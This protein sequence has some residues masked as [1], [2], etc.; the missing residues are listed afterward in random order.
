MTVQNEPS[1]GYN[2]EHAWNSLGFNGTL[3]RDFIKIDLGPELHS[4]GF[5]K[6]KLMIYDGKLGD[7][8]EFTD[9]VLADEEAAKYV[10]GVAFHWYNMP[11]AGR[12]DLDA[13]RKQYPDKFVLATEACEEWKGKDQHVWLGNWQTF[14]RYAEAIIKVGLSFKFEFLI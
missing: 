3:E 4:K 12:V 8:K 13:I 2:G 9:T 7:L 5:D 6:L 1:S 10:S 11:T 14:N